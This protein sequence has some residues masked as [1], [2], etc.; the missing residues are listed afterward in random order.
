[1]ESKLQEL[2]SRIYNEGIEKANTEA[3]I[4]LEN[5]QKEADRIVEDAKKEAQKLQETAKHETEEMRKNVASE[6][7]MSA[8]QSISAIKQQITSMVTTRLVAEPIKEAF[9]DK[10]FVKRIIET[11]IKNWDSKSGSI[12]LALSLPKEDAEKMGS[13]FEAKTR[14]TLNGK[15]KVELDDKMSGGFRIGPGDKSYVLSFTEEDF[16]NFFKNYLRPRT[17]KLLYGGE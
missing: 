9:K 13:Y 15:L 16:E 1:M 2:T 17:T 4:I 8:R 10:D 11:V 14:E 3:A 12:D 5:A 6:V 7:Q